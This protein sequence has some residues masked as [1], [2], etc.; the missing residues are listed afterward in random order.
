M[1]DHAHDSGTSLALHWF[2][3]AVRKKIGALMTAEASILVVEDDRDSLGWLDALLSDAGYRVKAAASFEE[4][5]RALSA[6]PDLL[7]TDVRLGAYNG[8]QLIFRGR[9]LNP[10]LP[11]IV[12]T[13][14]S[15]AALRAEAE[16]LEAAHLVKPIASTEL[17]S[18]VAGLLAGRKHTLHPDR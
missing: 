9:A 10:E 6:F 3:G 2:C 11:V 15:D 13:G 17:L 5:K 16:R 7:I 18:I 8:L 4:G 14:Y 1:G 12:I